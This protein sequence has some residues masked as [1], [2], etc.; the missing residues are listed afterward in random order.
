MGQVLQ[1]CLYVPHL[2]FSAL[3]LYSAPHAH[4]K[5]NILVFYSILLQ[6]VELLFGPLQCPLCISFILHHNFIIVLFL[7]PIHVE[8]VLTALIKPLNS[9]F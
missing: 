6:E 7:P 1:F 3:K 2:V 8:V 5:G 9:A 4:Q